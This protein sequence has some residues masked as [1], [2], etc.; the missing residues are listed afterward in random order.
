MKKL[1]T[2]ILI[3]GLVL[4][5]ACKSKS[6]SKTESKEI[7]EELPVEVK[8]EE[9]TYATDST[10]LKG[11]IA[12]DI[13][14]LNTLIEIA[15]MFNGVIRVVH[16]SKKGE[17]LQDDQLANK[18]MLHEFLRDMDH[19]FHRLTGTQLETAVQC[20]VESRDVDMITMVAKNLN[21]FQRILF[22]PSGKPTVLR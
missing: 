22:K 4:V 19:S 11:Y 6:E 9:V 10:N 5:A 14:V 3:A 21:Y 20:F 13:N 15:Q 1:I 8:G 2:L 7:S 18:E 12:Y 17:E 16:I